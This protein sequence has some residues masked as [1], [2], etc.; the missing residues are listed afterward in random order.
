[1]NY[2]HP[3]EKFHGHRDCKNGGCWNF[4]G[5]QCL[6]SMRVLPVKIW[7]GSRYKPAGFDSMRNMA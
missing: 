4:I 1:L 2:F 3:P 5:G 6:K 7:A